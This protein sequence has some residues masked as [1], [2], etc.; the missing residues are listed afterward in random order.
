VRDVTVGAHYEVT[1]PVKG[2]IVVRMLNRS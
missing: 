2:R 1:A